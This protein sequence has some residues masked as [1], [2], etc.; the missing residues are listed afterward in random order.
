[1]FDFILSHWKWLILCHCFLY[2]HVSWFF[3]GVF[4]VVVAVFCFYFVLRFFCY[5]EPCG[6]QSGYWANVKGRRWEN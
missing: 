3:S 2:L 4:L 1:M 6:S 5:S